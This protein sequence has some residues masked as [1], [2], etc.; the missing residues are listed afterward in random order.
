MLSLTNREIAWLVWLGIVLAT[1]LVQ[2]SM[3]GL[4]WNLMQAFCARPI[5]L[6]VG[7]ML[8]YVG[9][10]VL[11]LSALQLWQWD[12]LKTTLLWCV[13][14]AFVTMVD[15]NR[16]S[17][18]STFYGR[19][20]RDAVSVTALVLL[21]VEFKSFP[22]LAEF[23]IVPGMVF[24]GLCV[25][26]VQTREEAKDAR[27][28]VEGMASI[29]G[30]A[31]VI[32]GLTAIWRQPGEFFSWVTVR[33]FL[34]PVALSLLF[35][36]FMYALSAYAAYERIFL[37]LAFVLPDE[38]L[39]RYAKTKS[40]FAFAGNTD[41]MRRWG[42]NIGIEHPTSREDVD[43]SIHEVLEAKRREQSPP[44]IPAALGWSPYSAEA[45]LAADGLS[46][47]DYHKSFDDLW[48]AMSKVR[49][50]DDELFPN[51]ASYAVE[52]NKDAATRLKLTLDIFNT[53]QEPSARELFVQMAKRLIRTALPGYEPEE[54]L[55]AAQSAKCFY[56]RVACAD[57]RL[58]REDWKNGRLSGY[59][60]LLSVTHQADR[61]ARLDEPL[62]T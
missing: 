2:K 49:E 17:E 8:A 19:T 14:F 37:R 9:V 42:R 7:A 59:K 51:T 26:I 41:S 43:R 16:L 50:I 33:E 5:L 31:L 56:A 52:G 23:F 36:P 44:D 34:V 1:L 22:L 60:L 58:S 29:V 45:F 21:V 28:L 54:L 10:C 39:R 57:I 11:L 55:K 62:Q 24:L 30:L 3:R 18:D 47:D 13:T 4:L 53:M 20:V 25:A 38:P 48:C 27:R 15:V 35:L 32:Y 61:T 46:T 6:S 40:I 12:N